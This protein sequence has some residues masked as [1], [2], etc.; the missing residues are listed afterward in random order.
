VKWLDLKNSKT[1]SLNDISTHKYKSSI[2]KVVAA[3]YMIGD[4]SGAFRPDDSLNRA[5]TVTMLNRLLKRI[6]LSK[7]TTPSWLDVAPD[8]WGFGDIEAAS[9]KQ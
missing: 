9:R 7:D 4:P 5:E 2:E 6:P 1:T 3:G 8:Y